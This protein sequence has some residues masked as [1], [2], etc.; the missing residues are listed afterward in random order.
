ME[1][2]RESLEIGV[3]SK[4]ALG[5]IEITLS[6]SLKVNFGRAERVALGDEVVLVDGF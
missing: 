2:R 1:F 4:A 6:L 3:L 5:F